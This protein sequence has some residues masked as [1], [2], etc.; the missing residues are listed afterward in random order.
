MLA[1]IGTFAALVA[2]W[3]LSSGFPVSEDLWI[4]ERAK[5]L[6]LVS[7]SDVLDAFKAMGHPDAVPLQTWEDE[8]GTTYQEL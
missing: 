3:P 8:D 6:S 1:R 7:D 2:L 4:S 5:E